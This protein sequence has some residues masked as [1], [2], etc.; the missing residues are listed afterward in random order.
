M[1]SASNIVTILD[2]KNNSIHNIYL[3]HIV[4]YFHLNISFTDDYD[5]NGFQK[6]WEIRLTDHDTVYLN[7]FMIKDLDGWTSILSI[8][9]FKVPYNRD[10]F[11]IARDVIVT[12]DE[13]IPVYSEDDHKVGFHGSLLYKHEMKKV[14]D[15]DHT[16]LLRNGMNY[17]SIAEINTIMHDEPYGYRI[18][19]KSGF[20]NVGRYSYRFDAGI[21][22]K[23]GY[24]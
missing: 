4:P 8:T 6:V 2:I 7:D 1:L 15:I 19:T 18:K 20:C 22:Q 10:Y 9:K 14:S 5:E 21:D 13:M 17:F 24:H 11:L 3:G 12:E 16:A 23:I